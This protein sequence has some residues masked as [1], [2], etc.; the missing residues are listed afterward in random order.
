MFN[1][2]N[3][4]FSIAPKGITLGHSTALGIPQTIMANGYDPVNSPR[5]PTPADKYTGTIFYRNFPANIKISDALKLKF[6]K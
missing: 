4:H 3:T 1:H 5:K 2:E 6:T